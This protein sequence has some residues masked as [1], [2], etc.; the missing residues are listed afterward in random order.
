MSRW[1][2]NRRTMIIFSF[3]VLI[4]LGVFAFYTLV[5]YEPASCFDGELNGIEEGI[6]CGGSCTLVCPFQAAEPLV[7]W[8][9]S[10][11]VS[12]GVYNLTGIIENPNF[13]VKVDTQYKFEAYNTQNALIEDIFGDITLYPTEKKPVFEAAVNTGF[14]DISRVFLRTVGEPVWTKA[15]Q[16]EQSVFVTSRVLEDTDTLPKLRV[17]LVNRAIEPKRNLA[18]TVILYDAQDTASQSSKTFLEY[19]D[20]DA[21]AAVFFTWPEAFLQEITKIDVFIEEVEIF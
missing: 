11:E 17:D 21:T 19:I 4:A 1:A 18:I 3:I 14:Q 5:F 15:E 6:D 8:A 7:L 2:Q 13:D 9:R 12:D 16:R 10:F 20:R